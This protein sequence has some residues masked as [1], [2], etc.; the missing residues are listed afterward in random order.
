MVRHLLLVVEWWGLFLGKISKTS[1]K[2]RLVLIFLLTFWVFLFFLGK[3]LRHIHCIP[4]R[5]K[6]VICFLINKRKVTF[7]NW[8]RR[9]RDTA[10]RLILK[11]LTIK[12][13]HFFTYS[14]FDLVKIKYT[15]LLF[16]LLLVPILLIVI[17]H[18]SISN[19]KFYL[20]IKR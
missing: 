4:H 9:A 14:L 8:L 20:L 1:W 15:F 18:L 10:S 16:E 5:E 2:Q 17:H 3:I 11:S 13:S 7:I 12:L 6:S 19:W